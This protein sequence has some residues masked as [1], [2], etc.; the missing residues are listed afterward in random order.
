MKRAVQPTLFCTITAS[1]RG[2]C[3]LEPVAPQMA[4]TMRRYLAQA[5]T[6]LAP[7]S[8]DAADTALRQLAGFLT[9]KEPPVT[10]VGAVTRADV[11]EFKV[12]LAAR[13]GRSGGLGA[14]TQ[15]QRL[16]ML[17]VFFER[18]IEWGWD[19]APGR[20]PILGGDIPPRPEPLPRFLDDARA[21]KLMAAAAQSPLRDHLVVAMLARTGMRVGELCGLAA[22]A[23]VVIGDAHWLRVPLGKLRND[24]FVPL[25]AE[26]VE[27]LGAWIADNVEH[28]RRW[29]L[30]MVDEDGPMQRYKIARILDRVARQA[31]IGHVH[32]HQLR[33]TPSPPRP[34]T[35]GCASRRSP[36]SS[37]TG[38]WR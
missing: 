26:L 33:H 36:C 11:E 24:R 30:L 28:I 35:G 16:R 18:I 38:R 1:D 14:N 3:A 12:W 31:G 23:V 6:F 15:R 10:T 22:D 34:S 2:W 17:R 5:A 9:A 4:A 21:A 27:L 25:H 29:R 20:N 32:P 8:V 19:D 37:G 7:A 13:R